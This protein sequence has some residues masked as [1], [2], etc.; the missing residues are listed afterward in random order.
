MIFNYEPL[1]SNLDISS[2]VECINLGIANP[3]NNISVEKFLSQKFKIP[4]ALTSS[5]TAGS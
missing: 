3:S 1:V 2:V 4:C 5:G